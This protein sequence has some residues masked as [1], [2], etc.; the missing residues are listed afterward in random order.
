MNLRNRLARLESKAGVKFDPMDLDRTVLRVWLAGAGE[1]QFPTPRHPDGRPIT[2]ADLRRHY[3]AQS[4]RVSLGHW[5]FAHEDVQ[6]HSQFQDA[7][8]GEEFVDTGDIS[9]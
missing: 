7:E 8:F 4:S 6:G 9:P 2:Q 5:L 1:T 3:A